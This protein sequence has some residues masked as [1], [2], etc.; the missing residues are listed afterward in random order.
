MKRYGG[1]FSRANVPHAGAGR[2]LA[3]AAV[4]LALTGVVSLPAAL[5]ASS[6]APGQLYAFGNNYDGGLGTSTNETT[7]VPNPLASLVALPPASGSV[8]AVAA[9]GLFNLVLTSSGQLY[10][11]GDNYYG[12]LGNS[13]NNET[14]PSV[15]PTP[16]LVVLPGAAGTVTAIGAGLH[17]SL[18]GTSTGQLY[19]FGENY[20]GQ[21]GS[22][23]NEESNKANPTPT[24]VVLPGASGGIA[25]VA[26]G[27]GFSLALTSTGQ[28]Y[29][30]GDNEYGQL[31]STAS[32][33]PDATPTLVTL[34]GAAGRVIA[35]AAGLDHS[36]AL[37]STG[38]LYAFGENRYGQLGNAMNE[39]TSE[40]NATPS[41]VTLPGASGRIVQIAASGWDSFAL[42]SA[43]ELYAFG[44]NDFGQLGNTTNNKNDEEPDPTPTR[45]GFPDGATAATVSN[46]PWGFQ[47]LVPTELAVATA[48]TMTT[49]TTTTTT[50]RLR[51]APPTISAVSESRT[52]WREGD[53]LAQISGRRRKRLPPIGTA[54]SFSL[55]QASAV[56]FRFTQ[57]KT[58]HRVGRHCVAKRRTNA[59]HKGCT[60][61]ATAGTLPFT[62]HSGTNQVAFQGRLSSSK[63]L[64][65]GRYT[66]IIEATD[67]AGRAAP[68]RLTFTIVR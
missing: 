68:A 7:L 59:R 62:G 63:R 12:Q 22:A 53:R 26:A 47:T 67:A 34:P 11:F 43:G 25:Q 30:F 20:Y 18:V 8:T 58:G 55:N 24:L 35:I 10:A 37:T 29:A 38:Q 33:E 23:A 40:P 42:T 15:N 44:E 36:L 14:S 54:F 56:T 3:G 6:T 17:H 19:A 39:K 27:E 49:A 32:L 46:G 50:T 61:V 64:K 66:L 65:P 2:C 28:L 51:Q 21:L 48:T 1:G 5:A 13:A 57:T 4:A 60:R 9:G 16:T 52:R 41:L 45:V 31:G